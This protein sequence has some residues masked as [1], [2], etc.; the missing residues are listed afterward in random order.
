MYDT[1]SGEITVD[2]IPIERI[3]VRSLRKVWNRRLNK[4]Y[5]QIIGVVEQEPCLFNG[6]VMENIL[7]G[8]E[9]ITEKDA[10]RA[11]RI[12]RA[13]EFIGQL[14]NVT[15]VFNSAKNRFRATTPS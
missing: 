10:R 4:V 8:R 5:S 2:D 15:G 9:G 6:T 13:D 14:Q 1:V 7:L 11:A 3:N 12:A